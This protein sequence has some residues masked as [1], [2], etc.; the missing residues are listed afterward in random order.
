[1]AQN[2]RALLHALLNGRRHDGLLI[3]RFGVEQ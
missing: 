3:E 1:M 2:S